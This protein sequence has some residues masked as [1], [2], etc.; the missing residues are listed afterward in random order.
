MAADPP[1]WDIPDLDEPAVRP[2]KDGSGVA[3]RGDPSPALDDDLFGYGAEALQLELGSTPAPAEPS[4]PQASAPAPAV[5]ETSPTPADLGVP[6]P[7][8]DARVKSGAPAETEA[9]APTEVSEP[10]PGF[11][12]TLERRLDSWADRILPDPVRDRFVDGGLTELFSGS[13][14]IVGSVTASVGSCTYLAATG[15]RVDTGWLAG[16]LLVAGVG[17]I[18]HGWV[19]GGGS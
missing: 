8:A 19:R 12:V 11:R 14:L 6:A 1:S 15:E 10:R 16:L 4:P 2:P 9:V 5:E 13:L 18:V 17:L 7:F 3:G